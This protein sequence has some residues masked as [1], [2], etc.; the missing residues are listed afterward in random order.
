M[1]Q[2]AKTAFSLFGSQLFAV[3]K[4]KFYL[5]Q[6]YYEKNIQHKS[7]FEGKKKKAFS[8]AFEI[9]LK[10]YFL[11]GAGCGSSVECLPS[12]QVG[13]ESLELQ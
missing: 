3:D 9:L 1:T 8:T 4:I 13:D 5:F 11:L 7:Y 2:Q 10:M 6:W 12:R